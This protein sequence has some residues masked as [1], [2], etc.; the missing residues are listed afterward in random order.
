MSF[1]SASNAWAAK[2]LRDR[3]IAFVEVVEV[4]FE[5]DHNSCYGHD[6]DDYCYCDTGAWVEVR[7]S[8]RTKPN[9]VVADLLTVNEYSLH[10]LIR[11]ITEYP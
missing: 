3:K 11:E 5:I 1:E 2:E 8:Y 4:C 9:Q 10:S 7:I 6:A